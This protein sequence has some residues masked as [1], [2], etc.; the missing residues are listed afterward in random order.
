MR[1]GT[2]G[3]AG[4]PEVVELP[5][6]FVLLREGPL[7]HARPLSTAICAQARFGIRRWERLQMDNFLQEPQH[8]FAVQ[9]LAGS[10]RGAAMRRGFSS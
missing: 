7:D 5:T 8:F 3:K 1:V 9:V 2:V 4:I 10:A 6:L